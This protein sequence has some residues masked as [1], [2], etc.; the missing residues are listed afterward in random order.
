MGEHDL[1][2]E[3]PEAIVHRHASGT[4]HQRSLDALRGMSAL[5]VTIGHASVVPLSLMPAYLQTP[6]GLSARA[7][8]LL[9][10]VLSGHVIAGAAMTMHV[11][12]GFRPI[13]FIINRLSRIYPPFL[14]ALVLA[15]AVALLRLHDLIAPAPKL[16]SEPLNTSWF[17]FIRD[18]VFLFGAGTPVQNANAP[19]WSLRIEVVCY[20]L[21]MCLAMAFSTSRVVRTVVLTFAA[22]LASAALLRLESAGLGFLAFGAGALSALFKPVV[23]RWMVTGSF[24]TSLVLGLALTR[25][26]AN[27]GN[28]AALTSGGAYL[29]FQLAII[30]SCGL[31]VAYLTGT[32]SRTEPAYFRPFE[33]LAG[34]SYTLFIT[35][36][37]LLVLMAGFVPADIT[38]WTGLAVVVGQVILVT[39]FA[40]QAA[41]L[42]ERQMEIRRFVYARI[43]E[44][45]LQYKA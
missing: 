34:F 29:G 18:A 38:V 9:F 42:V 39:L 22:V 1:R 14:L 4:T 32:S 28:T 27:T 45:W 6:L 19:V 13:A 8:V 43:P 23:P 35:H 10:F 5:V 7:A 11:S 36:V 12:G 3:Q 40:W 37:P 26:V 17:A 33:W 20:I 21:T 30:A 44:R 2:R 25:T 31:L 41:R 24:A 16:M 15:W